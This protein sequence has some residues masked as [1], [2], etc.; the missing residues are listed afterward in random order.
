M[1][2]SSIEIRSAVQREQSE[3]YL[4]ISLIS[5]AGSILATRIFL[6]LTGYP[7]LETGTLHIAHVIWGGLF[8]FIGA[9]LPLVYANRWALTWSALF[10][11]IGFGLFMDE[12][13]KFI[14]QANDYFYPPAAPIIYGVVLIGVFIYL[15]VRRPRPLTPREELY[16]CLHQI[17]ELLDNDLD[18]DERRN[19]LNRLDKIV[20]STDDPHLKGLAISL[21][22]F[23]ESEQVNVAPHRITQLALFWRNLKSRLNQILTQKRF[24]FLLE[25]GLGWGGVKSIIILAQLVIF[26]FHILSNKN[27]ILFFDPADFPFINSPT[28]IF[29][30]FGIQGVVGVL[31]FIAA[32]LLFLRKDDLALILATLSLT[33]SLTVVDILVFYLD[34]F[35]AATGAIFELLLLLGVVVYRQ[36]FL[37]KKGPEIKAI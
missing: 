2:T 18:D 37:K 30:R 21:D 29:V 27:A 6:E 1:S 33:I 28:W 13:G 11:G 4:L 7:R 23:I 31:S 9:Q 19:L 17:E 3:Q 8:L 20:T 14:T 12:V 10:S 25:L 22:Q 26:S 34:Q 32:A 15:K 24:R 5:F 35:S 36:R 16:R